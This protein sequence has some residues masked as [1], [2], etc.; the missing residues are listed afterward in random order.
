M[1]ITWERKIEES[2]WLYLSN[3]QNTP[4]EL[5]EARMLSNEL[6]KILVNSS[7]IAGELLKRW[8]SQRKWPEIFTCWTGP[9]KWIPTKLI[10]KLWISLSSFKN[11]SN[12]RQ[13]VAKST[14]KVLGKDTTSSDESE[15]ETSD[16]ELE[17]DENIQE[18]VYYLLK[19]LA[20]I[21]S[22][23]EIIRTDNV[24]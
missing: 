18:G 10:L 24:A 15:S 12:F 17:D 22:S 23:K 20:F 5:W 11:K 4:T 21:I 19:E 13:D 6:K 2:L 8:A 9:E 14:A 1:S 7:R 3:P 16:S